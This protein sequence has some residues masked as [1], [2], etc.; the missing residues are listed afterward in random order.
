MNAVP[1]AFAFAAGALASVNPCGFAM[2]PAFVGFYLGA[3][4]DVLPRRAGRRLVEALAVGGA[5]TA[6]FALVFV[7]FGVL[8]SALGSALLSRAAVVVIAVGVLLVALGT[9]LAAG[10]SLPIPI[11]LDVRAGSVRGLLGA[12]GYGVAYALASLAC[13]LPVFLLVVGSAFSAASFGEGLAVF[14]A[15]TLG[16]GSVVTGVAVGAA[17]FRGVVARWL[18]RAVPL[19]QQLSGAL[20]VAAGVFLV[21]RELR[22]GRIGSGL[23]WLAP[24]YDHPGLVGALLLV[25][26]GVATA[27]LW[28]TAPAREPLAPQ[29]QPASRKEEVRT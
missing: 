26:A 16:M 10:R 20:L 25:A 4:G 24:A 5:V 18:R 3:D 13:T 7:G 15:F 23:D 11:G 1:L 28:R 17:L 12:G 21:V 27:A 9:W 29:G 19:V 14:G 8:V 6:G 22:L 2:L